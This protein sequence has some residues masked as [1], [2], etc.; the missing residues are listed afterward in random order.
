MTCFRSAPFGFGNLRLAEF[1][2]AVAGGLAEFQLDLHQAVVL[3]DAVGAAQGAG[4]D[5]AAVGRD[6]DVGDRRALGLAGAVGGGRS[7]SSQAAE[8]CLWRGRNR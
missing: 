8:G 7:T 6:G 1:L 3:G 2:V 5:L 4:L